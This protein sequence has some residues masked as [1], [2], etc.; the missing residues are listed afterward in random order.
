M[1][2]ANFCHLVLAHIGT[3]WRATT[4]KTGPLPHSS[5]CLIKDLDI[6][7]HNH[8]PKCVIPNYKSYEEMVFGS[9]RTFNAE[10]RLGLDQGGLSLGHYT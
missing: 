8:I 5:F 10:I 1:S 2:I 7:S 3:L 6:R 4:T 9:T